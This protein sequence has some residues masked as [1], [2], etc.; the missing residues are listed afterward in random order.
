MPKPPVLLWGYWAPDHK[1]CRP[2]KAAPPTAHLHTKYINV[3]D[4]ERIKKKC[5]I[6]G[7]KKN[8]LPSDIPCFPNRFMAFATFWTDMQSFSL[9]PSWPSRPDRD[10]KKDQEWNTLNIPKWTWVIGLRSHFQET[11]RSASKLLLHKCL[12]LVF[13]EILVASPRHSWPAKALFW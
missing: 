2:P 1:W 5:R 9:R 8:V 3:H 11:Y 12:G 4:G 13:A 10:G 7:I 6:S